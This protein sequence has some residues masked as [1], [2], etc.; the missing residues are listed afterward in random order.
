MANGPRVYRRVRGHL[1]PLRDLA[2]RAG[3]VD[4]ADNWTLSQKTEHAGYQ[5]YILNR[6]PQRL[7]EDGEELEYDEVDEEAD[8]AVAEENPYSGIKL[9]SQSSP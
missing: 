1:H 7:D 3:S 2:S 6:N 5:R 9:E 4:L 8:A